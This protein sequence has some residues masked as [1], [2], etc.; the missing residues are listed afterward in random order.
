MKFIDLFAGIGGFHLALHQ[1]GAECVFASEINPYARKTYQQNLEAISPDIFTGHNFAGD[2]ADVNPEDIPDFD[3]LCAGFPCQPFSQSG[4][5][6]GFQDK[7]QNRGNMFFEIVNILAVKKPAAFFL[8]NVRAIVK[9]DD[10]RTI[11]TIQETLEGLGYSFFYKV[12][13]ASDFGLPQH[14]PRVFMIG[15]KDEKT[16]DGSFEFPAS[17]P[18]T[19]T[20]S[21][22]FGRP[23][24]RDIGF[25]LRVGG[26]KSGLHDRR[27]WDAYSVDGETVYLTHVEGLKMMGFPE[28][29]TFPVSEAQAMKQLGN[30]VAVPAIQATAENLIKYL[31]SQS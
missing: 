8:E 29:F 31:G 15:F 25:T 3:V 9:H 14:R 26:R 18:L 28:D 7:Q 16:S 5:K 12:V 13:K 10:G 4:Y 19:M 11:K 21:D 2:I 30:S 17:V 20:M 24:T 23:C 6:K 27:N 22:V 1:A